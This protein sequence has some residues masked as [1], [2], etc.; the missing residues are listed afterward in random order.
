MC[1]ICVRS[2]GVSQAGEPQDFLLNFFG[3]YSILL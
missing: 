3:K 1:I 2:P